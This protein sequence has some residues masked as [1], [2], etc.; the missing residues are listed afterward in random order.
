MRR[1]PYL[2]TLFAAWVW[3]AHPCAGAPDRPKTQAF[4][5]NGVKIAYSVLGEGEPVTVTW[6][7]R[8]AYVLPADGTT[9]KD[10]DR[11]ISGPGNSMAGPRRR[12]P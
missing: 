7:P 1:L 5:S 11:P 9:E 2:S 3:A 8:D 4:D 12:N 10:P 6:D